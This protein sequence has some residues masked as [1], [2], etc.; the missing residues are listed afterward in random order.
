M[1]SLKKIWKLKNISI[2]GYPGSKYWFGIQIQVCFTPPPDSIIIWLHYS[3]WEIFLEDKKGCF[4]R[5]SCQNCSGAAGTCP[6]NNPHFSVELE[7]NKVPQGFQGFH[8]SSRTMN[9]QRYKTKQSS[10]WSKSSQSRQNQQTQSTNAVPANAESLTQQLYSLRMQPNVNQTIIQDKP[11]RTS[12]ASPTNVNSETL[13]QCTTPKLDAMSNLQI[14]LKKQT[15]HA[16]NTMMPDQQ[17][18]CKRN[19]QS[20]TNMR[21]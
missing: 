4:I 17:S 10:P 20:Q 6:L 13:S 5:K 1:C 21:S 7:M 14:H 9:S 18:Q 11:N 16:K 8:V 15:Q 2:P 19:N 3:P 12:A